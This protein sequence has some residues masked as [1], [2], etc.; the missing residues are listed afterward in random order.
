LVEPLTWRSDPAALL[1]VQNCSRCPLAHLNLYAHLLDLRS[2]LLELLGEL[3][4]GYF[5]SGRMAGACLLFQISSA[6]SMVSSEPD[7]LETSH[8]SLLTYQSYVA[9][10][11][12]QSRTGSFMTCL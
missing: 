2:L 4:D 9:L 12:S 8:C 5:L 10:F 7:P 11:A 3:R 1:I 6:V